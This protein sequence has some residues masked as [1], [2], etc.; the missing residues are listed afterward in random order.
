MSQKAVITIEDITNIALKQRRPGCEKGVLHDD[1]LVQ[2]AI[3]RVPPGNGVST[4]LHARVYG[5]LI[6]LK[7]STATACLC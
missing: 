3:Y 1:P 7:A 5:L 6:G 4:H 2:T